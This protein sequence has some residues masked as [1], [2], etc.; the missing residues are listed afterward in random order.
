[1]NI[2]IKEN[3]GFTLLEVIAVIILISVVT[4]ITVSRFLF[5]DADL[6]GRTEVIKTQLRYAQ[7]QAMNSSKIWGLHCNGLSY[8]LFKNGSISDDDKVLLPG[9]NSNTVDLSD[10]S[11]SSMEAFTISFDDRGIPY[12]D[13]SA[14]DGEELT[15][16]DDETDI[17]ISAG[18][19]SRTI[20]IT[21]NTGFIP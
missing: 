16:G 10:K 18:G 15:A 8:W 14:S 1:M 5:S 6:I 4:A 13:V 3:H 7:S 20:T 17:T 19:E 21:P 11:I 2:H 12:T 9:E